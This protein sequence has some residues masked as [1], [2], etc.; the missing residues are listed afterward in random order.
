MSLFQELPVTV[1]STVDVRR[2]WLI[3][4][5]TDITFHVPVQGHEY[6]TRLLTT[7]NMFDPSSL[8]RTVCKGENIWIQWLQRFTGF[9]QHQNSKYT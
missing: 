2:E 4:S 5:N 9:L 7:S 3:V 8:A 1:H 6:W